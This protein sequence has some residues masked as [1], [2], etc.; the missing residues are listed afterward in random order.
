MAASDMHV[1]T[2]QIN[3]EAALVRSA[4][5]SLNDRKSSEEKTKDQNPG[6]VK[7]EQSAVKREPGFFEKLK[8]SFVKEDITDIRD[9]VVFD[10]VIPGLRKGFFDM[11]VGTAG[12]IFG[13]SVPSS[14]FAGSPWA[15]N[16]RTNQLSPHERRYRD[17]SSINSTAGYSPVQVTESAQSGRLY[18]S[19]WA[20]VYKEQADDKLTTLMDICDHDGFLT[21][22]KF[23]EIV[24][25]G[26]SRDGRN[27]YTNYNYGW[28][29]ID[30]A[31]VKFDANYGYYIDG[32][33]PAR[34]L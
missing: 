3:P 21:A 11:I 27:P 31:T 34:P 26:S 33:P 15:P 4:R 25:P 10:I 23:L 12:Q 18:P 13:I 16:R 17:Y 8:R 22:A 30:N 20:W 28:R 7:R 19:D 1:P 5:S 6:A 14:T 2:P 24:D 32:L 9:Y 29:S